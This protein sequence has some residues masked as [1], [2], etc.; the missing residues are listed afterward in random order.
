MTKKMGIGTTNMNRRRFCVFC[1]NFFRPISLFLF[2]MAFFNRDT[3]CGKS[4]LPEGLHPNTV[5]TYR[6]PGCNLRNPTFQERRLPSDAEVIPVPDD[7]PRLP[8]PRPVEPIP[9]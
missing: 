1:A 4:K 5:K 9:L 3:Y 7:S 6:C 8:P 2:V